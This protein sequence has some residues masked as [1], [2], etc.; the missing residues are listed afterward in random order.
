M[1]ILLLCYE[2]PPIGG[3][4]GRVAAS[5]AAKLAERGHE[6]RVQTAALGSRGVEEGD[7]NLKVYR[8]ASFRKKPDTCRVHE[9]ALYLATSFFPSLRMIR[10]WKPDVM[11][12]HF[13][14]PTG[15]LGYALRLLT[16]VPYVMT[17]HLGDVPGGVP[18]QTGGLFQAVLPATRPIWKKAA[19]ATAVCTHTADLAE[20]AYQRRPTVILNGLPLGVTPSIRVNPTPRIV[21]VG[22]LA[23]QKDPVRAIEALG[24]LKDL[25]WEF[26]VV[27]DGP[28]REAMTNKADAL[29][30]RERV[31][32]HGWLD[33]PEVKAVFEKSDL[34][35]MTS[36]SEGLP[37]VAVE[38]TMNG[39]A[40]V[41]TR[42][43]GMTDVVEPP[44]NGALVPVDAPTA[45]IADALRL[46]L[47][48]P[49]R[50]RAAREGANQIRAKFDIEKSVDAYEHILFDA[51][52]L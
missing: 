26:D 28:F 7:G 45:E 32:F 8:S 51:A 18:E 27:G 33:A 42:A 30:I 17:A 40:I 19:A 47:S 11:H 20:N 1:K 22:R 46:Y 6:I 39:L 29:G 16:G 50:L 44:I 13:A 10:E 3:G 15:A 37:M 38:A 49:D 35:L 34:L 31:R 52:S 25:S 36:R 9:M 14:V 23:A 48:D 41:S 5:V 2:Y 21:M 4:G 12:V 43:G 24:E